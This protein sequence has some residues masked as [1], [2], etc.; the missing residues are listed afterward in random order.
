[1]EGFTQLAATRIPGLVIDGKGVSSLFKQVNCRLSL[2][3]EYRACV[4][5]CVSGGEPEAT[6]GVNTEVPDSHSLQVHQT[7][8]CHMFNIKLS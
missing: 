1:M 6:G 8:T 7:P 5:H 2:T 4:T 3:L